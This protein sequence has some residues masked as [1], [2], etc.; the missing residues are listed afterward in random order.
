MNWIKQLFS[1]RRLYSDLSEEIQEHLEE[2]IEELVA[3]GLS[4]EEATTAARRE[5]GNV[6]L[7]KER[8]REVWQWPSIE[9][10][11]M[12]VRYGLRM[13]AKNRG[14]TAVAVLTLALG[15]GATTAMFSIVDGA[16]LKPLP[17]S[18]PGQFVSIWMQAAQGANS[19]VSFPDYLDLRAQCSSLSGVVAYDRE[20]RFVN[21]MDESSLILVD[22]VSLNYFD[23]LGIKPLLGRTFPPEAEGY[24]LSGPTVVISY[25]LWKNRLGGDPGIVGKTIR[26]NNHST[27]VL[28]VTRE[29]FRGLNRFVPTD[30]W[31]PVDASELKRRDSRDYELVGRPRPGVTTQQIGAE[32]DAIGHRLAQ[33][34]PATNKATT[35]RLEAESERQRGFLL[36]SL[37]LMLVVGLVL[38]ISCANVAG[39]L[40]ARAETRRRE[41]AVR[42]ALGSSR[43]RLI[44]Q[45]LTEGL[46]LSLAGAALGLLLAAWLIAIE[47]SLLP[48]APIQIGP[49]LRIDGRVML[50]TLVVSLLATLIFGVAPALR[51]SKAD[52]TGA[53]KGEEAS[54][55]RGSKRM[56]ARNILVVGQVALSVLM[57]A[58]AGLFL[59]SLMSTLR[60]PLGFNP[61]RNLLVVPVGTME[62][63]EEQ[64]RTLLP[65]VLERV[66]GLPG[67][68]HATCAMRIPL[69]GS[70]GGAEL[71]V[72][73]PGIELPEGQESVAVKFNAVG[74]DYFQTVGTRILRGRHFSS[75]DSA[76]AP[77]VVL[78]SETMAHRF[79]P[80]QDPVGHSLRIEKKDYEII[81]VVENVKII[82][83][84]EAPEPYMYFPFAQ[85]SYGGELIVETAGDPRRW[86]PAVK[87][88]IRAVDKNAL[89]VWVQTGANVI[90]SEEDVYVQRAATGLVGSL[91]L[92]GMFLASVGLYGVVA[93]IAKLRTHE[94]GIRVA[95]GAGRKDILGLV[96]RQGLKL[97]VMGALIGL[98]VAFATTRFMSSLLYGVSPADPTALLGSALLAGVVA[99]VACYI[100]ARRATMVH[101]MMALRHE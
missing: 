65:R 81:G 24:A 30:A 36:V 50:F 87:R 15:I 69:S 82:H 27:T 67:I 72:S 78:I 14:F 26:L 21:S 48:P 56:A 39:L 94:I 3:S 29:R 80:N 77:K 25:T 33:A 44:R 76:N 8:S 55:G 40:L 62:G 49:D 19:E 41:V 73:I 47:P 71:R 43:G 68:V 23:V 7:I 57:L 17:V 64:R 12:D 35:F 11:F 66:Q 89:V 100:P 99:L 32:L 53:L 90:R 98:G 84:H 88:E 96:L 2:K 28:G 74:P 18:D 61:H 52:L 37:F 6:T 54:L 58:A 13:L 20:S 63:S 45:F 5:F 38:L 75:S 83:I 34:Y 59:K 42:L 51:A 91:S 92:L 31:L 70:G 93:Y 9:N 85:T 4:R 22:A 46:M 79:W 10:F 16:F 97:V 60:V 101:P 1:R 95:L 86:I